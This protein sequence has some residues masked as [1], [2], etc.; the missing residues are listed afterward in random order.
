MEE[1]SQDFLQKSI[2]YYEEWDSINFIDLGWSQ[3]KKYLVTKNQTSYILRLFK[4]D[5]LTEKQAEFNFIKECH[6]IIP[7]SKPIECGKVSDSSA[8]G[9]ILLSYVEGETL[10]ETIETFSTQKQ[11]DLGLRAGKILKKI[12]ELPISNDINQEDILS[13]LFY[14]KE[15]Q[16][17]QYIEGNYQL[18]HED[19]V[20]SYV[21]NRL[22]TIKTQK[23]VKQHGDFHP[24]NLIL[25]PQ[26]NIVV[27]DFN[28]WDL[29]DP[30]EEFLK[31]S[32]FTVE[33]SPVFAL[34]Q[35]EGYFNNQIPDIFWEQL[36][37][38]SLHTSLFSIV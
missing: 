23:I 17:N 32:L 20:I 10:E 4:S 16:L 19:E 9:Y 2:P 29:G 30:F 11:Y 37:F 15:R 7:C 1:N 35:I 24:G 38:Y 27:I 3:D 31:I 34:G 18:P 8:Y 12:H 36:K 5:K 13:N 33:T 28:R 21:K 6:D 25:T 14:K 26:N 22:E